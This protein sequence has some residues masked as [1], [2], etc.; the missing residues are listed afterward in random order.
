MLRL[1]LSSSAASLPTSSNPLG[2]DDVVS[3]S[4]LLPVLLPGLLASVPVVDEDPE[5]GVVEAVAMGYCGKEGCGAPVLK[6][7]KP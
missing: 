5:V 4:S 7:F 6:L 1:R 3:L 2:G